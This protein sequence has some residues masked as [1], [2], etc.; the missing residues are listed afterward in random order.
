MTGNPTPFTGIGMHAGDGSSAYCFTYSYTSP[1]LDI[2]TGD[3]TISISVTGREKVDDA[4]LS[5]AR[6][7]LRAAQDFAAEVERLHAE[8]A[9]PG[10]ARPAEQAA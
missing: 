7:L 5:F 10:T 6:E 8:Q 4:A 3:T 2:R 9:A 1:I